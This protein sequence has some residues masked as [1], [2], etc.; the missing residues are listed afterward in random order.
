MPPDSPSL[1]CFGPMQIKH[2]RNPPSKNPGYG[3]EY[4]NGISLLIYNQNLDM[5]GWTE[6]IALAAV[7]HF[8]V[9]E[10]PV[11]PTLLHC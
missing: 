7:H 2:P 4:L 1:V 8:P 3:P 10:V 11:L 6:A 5:H 9:I